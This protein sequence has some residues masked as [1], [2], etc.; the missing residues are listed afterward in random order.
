MSARP[1]VIVI[2]GGISGLACARRL[3]DAGQSV[4]VLERAH[5]LGGRLSVRTEPIAGRPHAVDLGAPYFTVRDP[6]FA[7]VVGRW[8]QAG[9]VREWTDR[10]TTAGPG[11]FTGISAGPQRWSSTGGL[12]S[13]VEALAEG[14]DVRLEH[15]VTR[16]TSAADRAAAGTEAHSVVNLDGEP[17]GTGA[18]SVLKVDGEPAAAV[19]LAM[20]DPQAARL[21]PPTVAAELEIANRPWSPVLTLWAAWPERCWPEFDGIF[22][23]DSPLSWVADSGR[24]RGDGAPVLVAHSTADLARQHLDQPS[25]AIPALLSALSGVLGGL[26]EPAW[27][28]AHRWT[29][30]SPERTHPEP[31]G[32]SDARTDALIGVCGDSWGPQSRVEQ[33]WGSGVGL[34]E[35]LLKRLPVS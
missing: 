26:P 7:E 27:V 12:R 29:L 33:A 24:S 14:I 4:R 34:A 22:V 9:R 30:A 31:F 15:S 18:H 1:P 23:S 16:V 13:L 8:Q 6:A 2:G 17:A 32:L 21:L 3:H 11:G 35:M 25:D 5:R 20:P 10:F 19:V 28:K